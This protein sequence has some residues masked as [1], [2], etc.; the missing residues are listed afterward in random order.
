MRHARRS[1]IIGSVAAT[2]A[3]FASGAVAHGGDPTRIHACIIPPQYL[4]KIV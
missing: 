3:V 1:I 2:A 4:V